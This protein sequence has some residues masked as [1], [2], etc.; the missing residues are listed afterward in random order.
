MKISAVETGFGPFNWVLLLLSGLVLIASPVQAH[1]LH[2]GLTKIDADH[3]SGE[4]QITHRLYIHDFEK[5]V[6]KQLDHGWDETPE[7]VAFIGSYAHQKFALGFDGKLAEL[8]FLGA[9]EEAEFVYIYFTA[10][11]PQTFSKVT[12]WNILLIDQFPEQINLNNVTFDGK[13][14]S[15]ILHSGQTTKTLAI[16]RK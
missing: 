2:A 10:T 16:E 13:T 7:T 4:I 1:R 9:E 15:A 12:V 5:V 8:A 11:I 3:N 6:Q 14:H